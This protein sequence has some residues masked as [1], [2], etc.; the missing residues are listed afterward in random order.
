MYDWSTEIIYFKSGTDLVSFKM[1]YKLINI[2]ER[3]S[4][5]P[6]LFPHLAINPLDFVEKHQYTE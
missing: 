1:S 4:L 6:Y 3:T 2:S 5:L